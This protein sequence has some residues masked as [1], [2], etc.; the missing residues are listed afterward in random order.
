MQPKPEVN[1]REAVDLGTREA[2]RRCWLKYGLARDAGSGYCRTS[3]DAVEAH[4]SPKVAD[5]ENAIEEALE[6]RFPR[7]TRD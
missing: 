5:S 6:S 2:T 4:V 1:S 7:D 3:R